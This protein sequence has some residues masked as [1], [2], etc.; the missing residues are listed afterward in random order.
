MNNSSLRNYLIHRRIMKAARMIVEEP[1][2]GLLDIALT[3]GYSTNEA[4]THAFRQI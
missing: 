2:T 3:Y 4:F 1:K